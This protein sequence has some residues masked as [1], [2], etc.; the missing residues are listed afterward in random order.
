MPQR[1]H[2]VATPFQ[3]GRMG[4]F[5][6]NLQFLHHSLNVRS[7]YLNIC[8]RTASSR[9]REAQAHTGQ[10]RNLR[11]AVLV[12]FFCTGITK[13][14]AVTCSCNINM[15]SKIAF[16]FSSRPLSKWVYYCKF[17]YSKIQVHQRHSNLF[18]SCMKGKA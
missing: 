1:P 14:T 8:F 17:T 2:D 7:R 5:L 12:F 10:Q 9:P 4:L 6:G 16:R 15:T 11:N 3:K 18:E 13:I